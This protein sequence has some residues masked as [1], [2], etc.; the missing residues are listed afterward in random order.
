M[1]RF[2]VVVN[3][4]S[5]DVEVEEIGGGGIPVARVSSNVSPGAGLPIEAQA[6]AEAPKASPGA[7][8]PAGREEVVVAPLPG[9][10]LDIKVAE[11]DEVKVGDVLL[12]LEAMKMENEIVSPMGGRVAEIRVTKGSA[13]TTGDALISIG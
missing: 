8:A 2:H 3:G 13:V 7:T 11:G 5:Y 4:L 10:V 1:R 9:T 12:V 6:P